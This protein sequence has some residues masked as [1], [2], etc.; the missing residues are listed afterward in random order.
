MLR[1]KLES[2][3]EVKRF[4]SK[5]RR[6]PSSDLCALAQGLPGRKRKEQE[7][8]TP[9][10][11]SCSGGHPPLQTEQKELPPLLPRSKHK[12][13]PPFSP[14]PRHRPF[15]PFS[16]S[17]KAQT[18]PPC[19][20][21]TKTKRLPPSPPPAVENLHMAQELERLQQLLDRDELRSLN[22]VSDLGHASSSDY[23]YKDLIWVMH[24]CVKKL[25]E[26]A[27]MM[28]PNCPSLAL[29][30]SSLSCNFFT[31]DAVVAAMPPC[32]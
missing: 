26:G 2:H 29:L 25:W 19:I 4:A 27:A 14:S 31:L 22:A 6:P 3:P 12:P 18:R 7:T 5:F 21:C 1:A 9:T 30:G 8:L 20:P 23:K 17:T 16:T 15:P 28:L 24:L 32:Y 10:A 13:F 11:S